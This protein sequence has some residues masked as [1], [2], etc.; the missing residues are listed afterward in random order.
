MQLTIAKTGGDVVHPSHR[1][2]HRSTPFDFAADILMAISPAASIAVK[3]RVL[4]YLIH[5]EECNFSAVRGYLLRERTFQRGNPAFSL[6]AWIW[7]F[8]NFK[9]DLW[10]RLLRQ[11]SNLQAQSSSR[12][13]GIPR[14]SSHYF[15]G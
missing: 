11:E 5:F 8:R 15:W 1:N 12:R 2:R 14:C 3:N 13:G 9:E 7:T 10:Q 6:S 4:P